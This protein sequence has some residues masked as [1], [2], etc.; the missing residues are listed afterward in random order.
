MRQTSQAA[1]MS[2]RSQAHNMRMKVLA[3]IKRGKARGRTCDEVE[4]ATGLLHQTASARVR[5]LFQ[6]GLIKDS[7]AKRDTRSGR[8]A[9]VWR[10]S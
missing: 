8:S 7:G 6:K 9:I 3:E 2:T 5:E 1:F 4:E 10:A